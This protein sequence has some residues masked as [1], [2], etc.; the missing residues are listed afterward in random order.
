MTCQRNRKGAPAADF[1]GSGELNSDN[2][3]EAVLSF[4]VYPAAGVFPLLLIWKNDSTLPVPRF[5]LTEAEPDSP[6]SC[7]SED[8]LVV[9]P[10]VGV[11]VSADPC[12]VA[13]GAVVTGVPPEVFTDASDDPLSVCCSSCSWVSAFNAPSGLDVFVE[14][15]NTVPGVGGIVIDAGLEILLLGNEL[16]LSIGRIV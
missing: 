3:R 2:K 4:E 7:G 13:A 15:K 11:V 10:E 9:G 16:G 8:D 14:S 5:E 1:F 12:V 6:R